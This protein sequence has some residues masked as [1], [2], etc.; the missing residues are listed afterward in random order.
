MKSYQEVLERIVE[1]DVL[2]GDE[3]DEGQQATR[4]ALCWVLGESGLMSRTRYE[5]IKQRI[6][7]EHGLEV[8]V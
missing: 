1:I 5:E 7:Q 2:Y 4:I 6:A 3:A 8:E